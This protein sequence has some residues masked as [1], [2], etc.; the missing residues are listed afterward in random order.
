[1]A[2]SESLPP[3]IQAARRSLGSYKAR[4][5]NPAALELPSYLHSVAEIE[6]V[7]ESI[8]N[9][10][11]V[12]IIGIFPESCSQRLAQLLDTSSEIKTQEVNYYTPT[13]DRIAQHK[14][15]GTLGTL[16]QR[17]LSG[18]TGLRN[19]FD[20]RRREDDKSSR[21]LKIFEF[22]DVYLDC[23]VRIRK[24]DRESV[25]ILNCLPLLS[26]RQ[27]S[28]SDPVSVVVV[29]RVSPEKTAE[30]VR[31]L[32]AF[33]EQSQPIDPRQIRCSTTGSSESSFIPTISRLATYGRL[34]REDVEPV[35]VIAVCVNTASG[36]CAL[37]KKRTRENSRDDF[38]TLSMISERILVEDLT[39]LLPQPV[40]RDLKQALD[41][42]W[43]RAGKPQ[44]FEIPERSFKHAAQ[45][46]LF[47][48]CG[49]DIAADRLHHQG[50]CLIDRENEETYLGFFIYRLDLVRSEGMDELVNAQQWNPDLT[51]VPLQE[52]YSSSYRPKLNRLLRRREHWLRENVFMESG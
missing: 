35:A 12:D 2:H 41:E 30:V 5:D 52:L 51:L 20:P 40:A 22:Y 23:I 7:L 27:N 21:P 47:I 26:V 37:L 24:S 17:R 46:E 43:I 36:P 9:A 1:M 42:L 3:E 19:C 8:I 15:P 33:Q 45:R 39:D 13:R 11:Q 14:Q 38:E 50:S 25:V 18:I 10:D 48:S 44:R 6:G 32:D 31:Y 4:P 49:L 16:V 28:P 34:M 29:S